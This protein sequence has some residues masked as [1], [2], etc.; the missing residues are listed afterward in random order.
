MEEEEGGEDGT[1]D[2]R[3]EDKRSKERKI[4]KIHRGRKQ[5]KDRK[6]ECEQENK[7]KE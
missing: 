2:D 1:T 5:G 4:K 6:T 7:R 3:E